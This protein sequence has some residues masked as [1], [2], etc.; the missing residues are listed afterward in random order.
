MPSP[1]EYLGNTSSFEKNAKCEI[2]RLEY[3]S[4]AFEYRLHITEF[5]TS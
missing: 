3:R 5:I 1:T 2:C 4:V